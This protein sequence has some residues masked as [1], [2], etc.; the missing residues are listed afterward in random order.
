MSKANI[1]KG[2]DE[3]KLDF[4]EGCGFKSKQPSM[5]EVWIFSGTTQPLNAA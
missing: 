1:F 3:P 2:K 5:G 4:P